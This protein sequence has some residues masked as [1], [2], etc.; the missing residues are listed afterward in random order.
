MVIRVKAG[1]EL[2]KVPNS[3]FVPDEH[4]FI[5]VFTKEG[6]VKSNTKVVPS[7]HS[8]IVQSIRIIFFDFVDRNSFGR[9]PSI[10]SGVKGLGFKGARDG[11][12]GAKSKI[13]VNIRVTNG[14]GKGRSNKDS[15][16]IGRFFFFGI[17]PI[18]VLGVSRK[19]I[20][21][22]GIKESESRV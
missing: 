18:T 7:M 13:T 8:K 3:H 20:R 1:N 9:G 14:V 12:M 5:N 17:I 6:S 10:I 21:G 15:I 22:R 16:Q 19:L 11:T 2:S 4:G